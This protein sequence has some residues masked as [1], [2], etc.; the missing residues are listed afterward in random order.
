MPILISRMQ[1]EY[2]YLNTLWKILPFTPGVASRVS[3]YWSID[4]NDSDI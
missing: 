3:E 2:I 4:I 1:L